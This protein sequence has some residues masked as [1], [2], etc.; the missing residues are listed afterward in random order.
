MTK[1]SYNNS[2]SSQRTSLKNHR[3]YYGKIGD[4]TVIKNCA[5]IKTHGL[6]V[7]PIKGANKLKNIT[8]NSGPEGTTQ[9]GEG[10]E[11]V[12]GIVVLAAVFFLA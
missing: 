6:E 3:G 7:T 11:L 5:I 10:C 1:N 9:I 4:R 8:I 12:N 2:K